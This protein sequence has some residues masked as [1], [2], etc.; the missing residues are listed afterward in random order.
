MWHYR[1]SNGI[2]CAGWRVIAKHLE[3]D[4][5]LCHRNNCLLIH[6]GVIYSHATKNGKSLNEVLIVLG[7]KLFSS[8]GSKRREQKWNDELDDIVKRNLTK[9]THQLIKFI[10]QLYDADDLPQWVFN[11]HAQYWLM[12]KWRI[13]I[14]TRIETGIIVCVRDVNSLIK[15]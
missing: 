7:E 1:Q 11:S 6:M 13:F 4:A 15:N 2:I 10:N 8:S 14:N 5:L 9:K 12:L 3:C